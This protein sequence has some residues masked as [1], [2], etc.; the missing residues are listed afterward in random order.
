MNPVGAVAEVYGIQIGL[1]YLVLCEYPLQF[2]R[3][4]LFLYLSFEFLFLGKDHVPYKLLRYGA[5]TR[6][7]S[8]LLKVLNGHPYYSFDVNT[9]VRPEPFILN[10]NKG[11]LNVL[12]NVVKVNKSPV[13][14][15]VDPVHYFAGALFIYYG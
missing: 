5:R 11:I 2:Y 8:S 1:Q 15:G 10:S 4:V 14:L 13:H 3:E 6:Y 7:N 12:W 9:K